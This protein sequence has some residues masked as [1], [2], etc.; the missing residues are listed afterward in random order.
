MADSD[1]YVPTQYGGRLNNH[2]SLMVAASTSYPKGTMVARDANG[3]AVRPGAGLP[4]HC[5]SE[6]D[7]DNSAG[8]NDALQ[9]EG[10][11]GVHRFAYTST[12]PKTHEIV[13]AVDNQTVALSSSSG[14]RGVAGVVVKVESGFV[15][16]LIDPVH[17]GILQRLLAAV[18][19]LENPGADGTVIKVVSGAPAW[20][21]DAT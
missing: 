11:L 19:L 17:N 20:A 3:R 8:A 18:Y 2:E 5:V 7:F 13:F 15:W 21:A 4:I 1:I 12:A 9:M 10:A 14:T 6:G 16:V